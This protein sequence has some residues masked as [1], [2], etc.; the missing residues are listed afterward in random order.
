MHVHKLFYA[1]LLKLLMGILYLVYKA[2]TNTPRKKI[3]LQNG[4]DF[5]YKYMELIALK[6][7]NL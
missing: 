4:L 1:S 6:T 2:V 5:S 7:W 3:P